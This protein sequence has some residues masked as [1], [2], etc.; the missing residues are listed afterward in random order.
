MMD[1]KTFIIAGILISLFI[2]IVAVFLA[3]GDPD[4][5]ESSALVISGQK[6]LTGLAPEDGDPEAIGTGSFSYTSPMPD[7]SLDEEMGS[8]GGII[9]IVA[10]TLITLLVVMGASYAVRLSK[11]T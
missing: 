11:N 9:A 4:G 1:N 3:S 6:T 7:Y 2:G 8:M 5:L 10:G